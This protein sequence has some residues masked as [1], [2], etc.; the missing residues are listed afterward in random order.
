M[1]GGR[2]VGV[3]GQVEMEAGKKVGVLGLEAWGLGLGCTTSFTLRSKCNL[4]FELG[5]CR[6]TVYY[7]VHDSWCIDYIIHY[8]PTSLRT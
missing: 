2:G 4:N 3:R 6:I 7:S 1:V 5:L 8:V